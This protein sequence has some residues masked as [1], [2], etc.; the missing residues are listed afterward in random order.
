MNRDGFVCE[1]A[2]DPWGMNRRR[3]DEGHKSGFDGLRPHDYVNTKQ[4]PRLRGG[5]ANHAGQV[6]D[7][8]M[9]QVGRVVGRWQFVRVKNRAVGMKNLSADLTGTG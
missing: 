1:V 3:P 8:T 6:A 2:S 7:T 9:P 5:D 4:R